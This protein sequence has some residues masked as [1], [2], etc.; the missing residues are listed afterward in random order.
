MKRYLKTVV[1]M[2]TISLAI[3]TGQKT[4]AAMFVESPSRY[5]AGDFH[6]HT[7]YTDGRLPF[8]EVMQAN[9]NHGL[10]FWANSEHGGGFNRDG[11]GNYWDDT[12]VYPQNPIN[13]ASWYEER[14]GHQKMW[15]WQTLTE[16]AFAD[17]LAARTRYPNKI[18]LSG[19]EWNVPGHEHCSTGIV[20]NDGSA[21]SAFEYMFDGYDKD[22]SRENQETPF[23]I[24]H[25][26]NGRYNFVQE[27]TSVSTESKTPIEAHADAVAA[28]TWLQQQYEAGLIQGGY[29]VFA[30]IERK[31]TWSP[32]NG[33]G[34]NIN[35]FRDFNNAGP[36]VAFGFEGAPGHQTSGDRGFGRSAVGG[37]TYGGT[38]W[39][40]A[41]IGGL[42]DA[43]LGEGRN[44]WNFASSDFH[45][46]WSQGGSDFY[47]GEYQKDYVM[48]D[49]TVSNKEA[50]VVDGLR[51]GNSWWVMGD[52]I[53]RLQFTAESNE[54]IATMGQTL[55]V[56][57]G[58][59]VTIAIR[60]H[61]PAGKNN[62]PLDINNPSLAQVGI[63]QP[64]A[65]PVLDHVDLIMGDVTGYVDPADPNYTVSV[66]PSTEVVR[67]FT[68]DQ[69]SGEYV[70]YYTFT[71]E[72]GKNL[73]FRLR[74]TN[75]PADVPYETDSNGNP[76]PDSEANDNIYANLD[77]SQLETA[78]MPGVEITTN[79]KLDDVAEAY[80]D[81]WFYSN[82]IF[83]K[84]I[85]DIP[86][87]LNND[88]IVDRSDL[89]VIRDYLRQPAEACPECDIDGDG[90][91]T[92]L[93]A[94]KLVNI[95]NSY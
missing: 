23:G 41:T 13:P 43:L 65:Q 48:V 27:E 44:W 22:L 85:S 31:G 61:D 17:V 29:T 58:D 57:A 52:L 16:F 53:D 33:G 75:L 14:S 84:V 62:C 19:F 10:D 11:N 9:N 69:D 2:A 28:V 35:H 25:K 20:S 70:F 81:L 64:L 42:W 77:T 90:R 7:L 47:P 71:A 18:I 59:T 66:N 78:L 49:T 89:H 60:V 37:G 80:A 40:T 21:I 95:I 93:D 45:M 73:Y 15:R 3:L 76:L 5:L 91:I 86:G 4:Q 56:N 72:A 55:T 46:H 63:E 54:N 12:D 8:A 79:S 30:H 92:I 51:S 82:P 94:R 26:Q 67:T 87:D 68:T 88:G 24:L 39:Y 36:D 83:I 74:G 34:Y 32:E 38:G 50:A 6:Q 1:I